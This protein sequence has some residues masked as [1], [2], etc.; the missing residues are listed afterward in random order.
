MI[1]SQDIRAK[2]FE[3][4]IFGGYDM[5][6][7]EEFLETVARAMDDNAKELSELRSKTTIL[8]NTVQG[9]RNT[10]EAMRL[11]LVSAQQLAAQIEA[12]AREKAD[13]IITD[14]TAQSVEILANLKKDVAAQEQKLAAAQNAF[15]R[16]VQ[17]ALGMCREMLSYLENT[18]EEMLGEIL[19]ESDPIAPAA[20]EAPEAPELQLF[21]EPA[22]PSDDFSDTLLFTLD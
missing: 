13:A 10:E 2:A 14:A 18:P 17:N 6:D 12:D 9:Y 5:D 4:A 15:T 1:T 3:K 11:A 21:D 20:P 19:P 16:F 7:V 22:I 8:A